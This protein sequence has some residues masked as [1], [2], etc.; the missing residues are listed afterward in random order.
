MY[1]SLSSSMLVFSSLHQKKAN[2]ERY[3]FQAFPLGN[4]GDGR[5]DQSGPTETSNHLAHNSLTFLNR[6]QT[7]H[8][9]VVTLAL[10]CI[11]FMG[12]HQI[13]VSRDEEESAVQRSHRRTSVPRVRRERASVFSSRA[14]TQCC[15]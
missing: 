13:T 8:L 5:E 6:R 15:F 14:I 9:P 1:L 7:Q 11:F 4:D 2:E 12:A 3:L 10:T